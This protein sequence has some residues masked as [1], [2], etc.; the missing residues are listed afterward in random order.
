MNAVTGHS[1]RINGLWQSAAEQIA[2]TNSE[3]IIPKDRKLGG[4]S[5]KDSVGMARKRWHV[6]DADPEHDHEGSQQQFEEEESD[7][8][9]KKE[10]VALLKQLLTASRLAAIA[11]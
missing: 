4:W 5:A 7:D 1:G 9:E 3:T 10:N 6:L 8:E 2:E 11:A